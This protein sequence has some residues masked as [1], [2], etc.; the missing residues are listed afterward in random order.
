VCGQVGA[1]SVKWQ[2]APSAAKGG[3]ASVSILQIQ[4]PLNTHASRRLHIGALD[5]KVV[6][7]EQRPRRIIGIG[8]A[9]G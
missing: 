4:K 1:A 2:R 6:Q 3:N 9:A 5:L 7:R 8:N